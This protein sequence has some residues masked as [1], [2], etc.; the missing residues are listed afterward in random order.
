MLACPPNVRME[1]FDEICSDFCRVAIGSAGC[2]VVQSPS[3]GC[4]PMPG[5][6]HNTSC[7]QSE[8]AT[9]VALQPCLHVDTVEY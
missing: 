7:Q 6:M 3:F 1:H 5:I 4:P 8:S 9:T 2:R